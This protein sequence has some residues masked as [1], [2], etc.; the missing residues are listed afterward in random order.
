MEEHKD[1]YFQGHAQIGK[2][3]GFKSC[4]TAKCQI[5]TERIALASCSKELYQVVNPLSNRYP[6]KILPTIYLSAELPSLFIK[7]TTNKVE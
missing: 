7:Y 1:N 5:Y 4:H 6:P 2:A 3:Q